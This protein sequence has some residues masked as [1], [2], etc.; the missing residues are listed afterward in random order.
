MTQ[1][2]RARR[3]GR[4][5]TLTELLVVVA[6]LAMLATV[7]VIQLLR[8]RIVTDEQLALSSLRLVAKSAQFFFLVQQVY[9]TTLADLGPPTSDPPYIDESLRTGSPFP[10]KQGYAFVYN[11]PNPLSFT[12]NVNPQQHGVT[13]V[14]HFYVDQTFVIHATEANQDAG[15]SDPVIP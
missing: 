11:C 2:L 3:R 9:P 12:L 5:F 8:A 13:G 14:R 4:G 15:T 6:I 1:V 10:V 7:G